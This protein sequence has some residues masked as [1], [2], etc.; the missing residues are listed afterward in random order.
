MKRVLLI[1]FGAIGDAIMAIPAAYALHR[2]GSEVYWVCGAAVAPLL[3]CYDWIHPIAADDRAILQGSPTERIK[4]LTS[5]WRAIGRTKYDLC[6]ILY[7]DPRYRVLSLPVRAARKIMLSRSARETML[8]EGRHHTD[9][10][11][12]I[13]LGLADGERPESLAPVRP[14]R[15]PASPLPRIEGKPRIVLIPAGAKNMLR[16]DALRRWPVENY[17]LLASRLL[18]RGFEVVL[19]GGPQD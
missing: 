18:E 13:L 19:A 14:D 15:L 11:A 4:A 17:V 5:L 6:A 16:D 2:Q 12:R 9:E 3:A 7:Y 1:K 8:L 10:Y